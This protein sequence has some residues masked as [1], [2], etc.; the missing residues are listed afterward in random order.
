MAAARAQGATEY[1][2]LLAVVL[3]VALVSV[4]LLGFFPGMAS[5]AQIAQSQAYWQSTSPVAIT[6]WAAG[7]SDTS[8]GRTD[9]YLRIRNTGAY[10]VTVTKLLAGGNEISNV[11]TGSR[12]PTAAISTMI[13]M[14]PGEETYLGRSDYFPGVPEPGTGYRHYF[15]FTEPGGTNY[16]ASFVPGS[17]QSYCGN[18][19][20]YGYLMVEDFGFEYTEQIE[21]QTITKRQVGAKPLYIRCLPQH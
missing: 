18:F 6:E 12:Y 9:V 17:A 3:I 11:W 21:G 1:L 20:P 19:S 10:K 4:A 14:A 13:S 8:G 5:D 2:V 16:T 7:R 15:D